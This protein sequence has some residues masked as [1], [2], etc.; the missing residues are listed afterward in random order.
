MI[1]M[2]TNSHAI[3]TLYPHALAEHLISF[4]MRYDGGGTEEAQFHVK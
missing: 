2:P 1:H 3:L 4:V